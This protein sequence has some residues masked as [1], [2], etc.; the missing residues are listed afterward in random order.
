MD[1]KLDENFEL[2]IVNGD[3]VLSEDKRQDAN[4]IIQ[5]SPGGLRYIPTI[6]V[7][8]DSYLNSRNVNNFKRNVIEETDKIDVDVYKIYVDISYDDWDVDVLIKN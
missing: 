4:L 3:F 6:G 2:E 7:G 8:I 5:I 1:F